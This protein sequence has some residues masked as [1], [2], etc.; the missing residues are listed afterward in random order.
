V[1]RKTGKDRVAGIDAV[2]PT[3]LVP[4]AVKG[5]GRCGAGS[6]SASAKYF[7]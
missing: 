1:V 3:L 2:K 7:S 5:T 6:R 4:T